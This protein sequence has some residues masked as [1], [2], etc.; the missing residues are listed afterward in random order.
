MQ[1]AAPGLAEKLIVL[2]CLLMRP[3]LPSVAGEAVPLP[4]V[5]RVLGHQEVSVGDLSPDLES[6]ACR[7]SVCVALLAAPFHNLPLAL[8]V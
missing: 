2:W 8:L 5:Y 6:S 4:S 7:Y 1:G 3:P